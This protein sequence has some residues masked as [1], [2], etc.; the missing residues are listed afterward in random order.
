[1]SRAIKNPLLRGVREI[2][3]IVLVF[4]FNIAL[5]M[6]LFG[7]AGGRADQLEAIIAIAIPV[8]TIA[9]VWI[10]LAVRK[11]SWAELGLKCGVN[12]F[13]VTLQAVAIAALLFA[14]SAGTEYLGFERNLAP[15]K[16]AAAAGAGAVAYNMIYAVAVIGFYE[17][18]LFRGFIMNRIAHMFGA[19]AAAW[20]LAAVVQGALFGLS[21]MH[22]GLYGVFYT[23][24]LSILLAAVFLANGRNLW[25][26]IFGHGFYDAA[27]FLYFY[28]EGGAPL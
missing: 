22:Q 18:I 16:E 11:Q 1:M 13:W 28:I 3:D 4:G 9:F 10:V 20:G 25:P 24:G 6:A 8:L 15:L 5:A 14:I 17:E 26:L 27:R 19:G 12:W 7:L 23:G 21:H 2:T